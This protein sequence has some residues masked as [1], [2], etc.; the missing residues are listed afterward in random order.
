[1]V[2]LLVVDEI[3]SDHRGA[4]IHNALV[5]ALGERWV[6]LTF[7][8]MGFFGF[9]ID[10]LAFAPAL[11]LYQALLGHLGKTMMFTIA[12]ALQSRRTY[13]KLLAVYSSV[14]SAEHG[15]WNPNAKLRASVEQRKV[16]V[17]ELFMKSYTF[18]IAFNAVLCLIGAWPCMAAGIYETLY[19][20]LL[21]IGNLVNM[22]VLSKQVVAA[23]RVCVLRQ[24]MVSRLNEKAAKQAHTPLSTRIT[25]RSSSVQVVG[26]RSSSVQVFPSPSPSQALT[27]GT[28]A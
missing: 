6:W 4:R 21:T 8:A 1:V 11:S 19:P 25:E 15:N 24:R 17:Q 3:G 13:A 12:E 20:A 28:A 2:A 18:Q 7:L 10:S 9:S 22:V 27:E 23:Q 5:L 16:Q 26:R 14:A